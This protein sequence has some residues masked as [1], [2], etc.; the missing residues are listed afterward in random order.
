MRFKFKYLLI[1]MH[2]VIAGN[3]AIARLATFSRKLCK[4][5][6]CIIGLNQLCKFYMPRIGWTLF[7]ATK[8]EHRFQLICFG[9]GIG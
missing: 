4:L 3:M 9:A 5:L 8:L 2:I 1:A 6:R 7:L